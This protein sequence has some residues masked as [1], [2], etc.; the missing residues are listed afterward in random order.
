ML[1]Q[2]LEQ[3]WRELPDQA[4]LLA[5]NPDALNARIRRA[6][7][8]ALDTWTRRN[9]L[10][11]SKAGQALEAQC[12]ETAMAEW[13]AL[14][15]QREPFRV[16]QL[17]API[18]LEFNGLELSGK[19]DRIDRLDEGGAILID[20]KTGQSGKN[21][22]V[23]DERL[24]DVQLP[25]Y[26]VS[27]DPAPAALVFAR[28]RPEKMSFDGLAEVDPGMSGVEV[29]GSIRRQPFREIE[30]WPGLIGNWRA[31]L[32]GLADDFRHGKAEVDP[33]ASTVCRYCH[34]HSLCRINERV[35][36]TEIEG[37]GS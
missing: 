21:G 11:L 14:E 1:H 25:A 24:A 18:T 10:G 9:R 27:L 8:A 19:I 31:A 26:A 30:S 4:A 22:W 6:V 33:R 23:P 16:D 36:V 32:Q 13:L 5:L 17:E 34:L 15:K 3:F 2:A 28:I 20:Y 29:I 37:D 12:L 7:D 35:G